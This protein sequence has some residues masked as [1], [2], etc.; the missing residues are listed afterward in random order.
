MATLKEMIEFSAKNPKSPQAKVLLNAV[1]SGK[2]DEMAKREKINLSGFKS[3]IANTSPGLAQGLSTVANVRDTQATKA[4][5]ENAIRSEEAGI[6]GQLEDIGVGSNLAGMA[7]KGV[8]DVMRT[9]TG[10]KEAPTMPE[11]EPGFL[12]KTGNFLTTAGE[13]AMA[14]VAKLPEDLA[15]LGGNIVRALTPKSIEDTASAP[16]DFVEAG[17]KKFISDPVSG[18]IEGLRDKANVEPSPA[19]E[20]VGDILGGTAKAIVPGGLG[21]KFGKGLLGGEGLR[22][23]VQGFIGGSL[24]GTVGS[25]GVTEGRLPTIEDFITGGLLDSLI[26]APGATKQVFKYLKNK[27]LT[28]A[29]DM[30]VEEVAN[31]AKSKGI[32][33]TEVGEVL[34]SVKARPELVD[35]LLEQAKSRANSMTV[36]GGKPKKSL[37]IV[38]E[39]VKTTVNK[40]FSK[41]G[42]KAK[43]GKQLGEEFDKLPALQKDISTGDLVAPMMER[44]RKTFNIRKIDPKTGLPDFAGSSTTAADQKAILT[45]W[46][47]LVE[48]KRGINV[49]KKYDPRTIQALKQKL[50]SILYQNSK[51]VEP[52]GQAKSILEGLRQDYDAIIEGINPKIKALNQEYSSLTKLEDSLRQKLRA[53]NIKS[54]E[55]LR[56]LWGDTSSEYTKLV[57]D[58]GEMAAKYGVEEGKDLFSKSAL[59]V[60]ID[61][62]AGAS[63]TGLPAAV[64]QGE[65]VAKALTAGKAGILG[66]AKLALGDWVD[67]LRGLPETKL[68]AISTLVEVAKRPVA[69]ADTVAVNSLLSTIKDP[70]LQKALRAVLQSTIGENDE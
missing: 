10:L 26:A 70:E 20:F 33:P 19:G 40:L 2:M 16:F 23:G 11:E 9:K 29:V 65:D 5:I 64:A 66:K 59:A 3:L 49:A 52:F 63:P 60:T 6:S 14:S 36:G 28:K 30:G 35:K 69:A 44:L 21:A 43:V 51:S 46:D 18:A 8:G 50:G 41:E 17:A 31:L 25:I 1:S 55:L 15:G 34:E 38:G 67:K 45:A 22:K 39:D 62:A 47:D 54:P 68:D 57:G 7:A 56:R 37:D 12:E 13:N 4:P 53:D 42:V 27:A 24:G 58:L 61:K 48:F 32:L